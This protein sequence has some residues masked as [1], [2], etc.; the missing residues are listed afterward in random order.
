MCLNNL[1]LSCFSAPT[2]TSVVPAFGDF[3][4][5]TRIHFSGQYLGSSIDDVLSV[6]LGVNPCI[7][8]H[9]TSTSDIDCLSTNEGHI[10]GLVKVSMNT[11]LGGVSVFGAQDVQYSFEKGVKCSF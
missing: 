2:I 3:E 5:G 8:I 4:G 1:Y 10:E 6:S 7:D 11:V 9:W